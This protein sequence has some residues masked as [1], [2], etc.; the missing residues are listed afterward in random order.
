ME[1]D[2]GVLD[3]EKEKSPRWACVWKKKLGLNIESRLIVTRKAN[4]CRIYFVGKR[5]NLIAHVGNRDN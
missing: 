5:Q 4:T 3:G 1:E 2:R